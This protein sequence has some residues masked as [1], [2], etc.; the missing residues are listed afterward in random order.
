MRK[1]PLIFVVD[2]DPIILKLIET[3]LRTLKMDV[4]SF[5]FGEE[6]LPELFLGPDIIILDY[7]FYNRNA[8]VLNGLEILQEIRKGNHEAPVIMLSGQESGS[9][10]LELI[11]LGI[12]E[13]IIKE[14]N[15]IV[16]LKEAVFNALQEKN[17]E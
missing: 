4:M 8:P 7:V 9:A 11:K 5:S 13:Y 17:Q 12:E 15:F 1:H 14:K 16:N 3:E 10:V 2:D 6:F